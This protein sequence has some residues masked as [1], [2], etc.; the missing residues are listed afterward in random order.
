MEV[1]RDGTER[2]SDIQCIVTSR[3]YLGGPWLSWITRVSLSSVSAKEMR[4]LANN[5][6][7]HSDKKVEAFF[8]ELACLPGIEAMT[9]TPLLATLTIL[10]YK[11]TGR[12]PESRARLYEL[13]VDLLSGGWDLAKGVLRKTRF[14]RDVKK[15]ILATLAY[16]VHRKGWRTFRETALR[17]AATRVLGTATGKVVAAMRMEFLNDSILLEAGRFLQ[18]RHLS[19][20][21]FLAARYCAIQPKDTRIRYAVKQLLGSNDWWRSVVVF[22]GAITGA[23]EFQAWLRQ[24]QLDKAFRSKQKE[25]HNQITREEQL[26]TSD[27][28]S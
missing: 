22:Y 1:V 5:W 7:A 12:L 21:E 24:V 4:E 26:A 3:D 23:R 16:N 14:T 19:F 27:S 18:F 6:L 15:K 11:Q 28:I 8:Q 17:D 9:W 10:V 20:Q 2:R 13:F 25:V